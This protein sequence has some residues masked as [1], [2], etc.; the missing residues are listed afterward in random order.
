MMTFA[1]WFYLLFIMQPSLRNMNIYNVSEL[2]KNEEAEA[3]NI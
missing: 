3:S 1:Y 2:A